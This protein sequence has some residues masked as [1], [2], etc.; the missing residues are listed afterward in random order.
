MSYDIITLDG[1]DYIIADSITLNNV[2]YLYVINEELGSDDISILK[3]TIE[4]GN[5]FV[6]SITDI[7]EINEVLRAMHDKDS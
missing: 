2:D 5:P 7:N 6:E 3:K 4:D 1:K